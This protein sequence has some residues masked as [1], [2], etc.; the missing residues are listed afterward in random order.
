MSRINVSSK[1]EVIEKKLDKLKFLSLSLTGKVRLINSVIHS[2]LYN[3]N[4]V[5]LPPKKDLDE[6]KRLSFQFLW[7]GKREVIK[8]QPMETSKEHGGL[9]LNNLT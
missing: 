9:G 2:Q 7:D 3:L 6:I 5:Y 4:G 8:R 1:L